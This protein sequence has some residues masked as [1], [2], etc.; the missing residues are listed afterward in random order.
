MIVWFQ[1]HAPIRRKFDVMLGTHLALTGGVAATIYSAQG[2]SMPTYVAL[3]ATAVTGVIVWGAKQLI[4]TPYVNTV[5]RME[6]LARGDVDTPIAYTDFT[7]CVGRMT[8]A[9]DVFRANAKT[10]QEDSGKALDVVVGYLSQALEAL[11]A[12]QLHH[13]VTAEFPAGYDVL[14]AN[15]NHAIGDLEALMA[16][17]I[18]SAGSVRVGAS[19]IN[20]ASHDLAQRTERQAASLAETAG[21]MAAAT[22]ALNESAQGAHGASQSIGTVHEQAVAGG[23][24]VQ[25]AVAAMAAIEKS[26][27]EIGQIINVIDG[28]AFQTNLL[29]LN[30]GVEAARAGDAGRGFA[31]VANEVRALAQRCAD[32][33]R[34]I[35][36]LIEAS[37]QQVA[38]GVRLVGDTGTILTEMLG[39]LGSV[40]EAVRAISDSAEQ[41]AARLEQ[42][43]GA[44]GQMDVM[45]QQNAAMVEQSTAAARSLA[46]EADALSNMMER[47]EGGQ[48]GRPSVPVSRPVAVARPAARPVRRSGGAALA[49]APSDEDWAEF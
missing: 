17:V 11:A 15:F 20:S 45:T 36:K 40:T 6:A 16:R 23:R 14:K 47:F 1:K 9:M 31:V 7:D 3:G 43:N 32:S 5:V 39:R 41:Q 24:V 30:A 42:I 49:V 28:I 21:A 26:A 38:G 33:A 8:R 12:G 2:W 29:A 4:C 22:R 35:K 37:N 10:L 19:E 13:R 27:G 48:G 34:D 25:D 46:T 44:V 18:E